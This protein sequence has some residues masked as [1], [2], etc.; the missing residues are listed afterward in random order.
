T[1]AAALR[2]AHQHYGQTIGPFGPG[3]G[4]WYL[5]NSNSAGAPDYAPFA[6][7]AP[8]WVPV[9]GDWRGNGQTNIGVF[10]PGTGTWYLR[11]SNG[12]GAPDYHPFPPRPP[13]S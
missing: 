9:A 11:N 10:D 3:T 1:S 13:A 4:T 5:R 6:Y 2:L 7:G 8:G 12:P